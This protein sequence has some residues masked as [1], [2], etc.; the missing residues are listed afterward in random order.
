[1]SLVNSEGIT[2]TDSISEDVREDPVPQVR[3][4]TIRGSS[5]GE[6]IHQRV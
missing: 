4:R 3:S 6:A 2:E 1:V 5:Q